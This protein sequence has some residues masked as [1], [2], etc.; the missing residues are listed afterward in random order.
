MVKML[1]L[2]DRNLNITV[3]KC[4]VQMVG[5]SFWQMRHFS[6]D[7]E[8]IKEGKMERLE[9]KNIISEINNLIRRLNSK[10][11]ISVTLETKQFKKIPKLMVKVKKIV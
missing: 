1:D 9:M 10:E 4:L 7:M 3:I 11:K 5:S 2:S 6:R 8:T